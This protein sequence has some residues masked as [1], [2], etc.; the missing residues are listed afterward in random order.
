MSRKH[1]GANDRARRGAADCE[2]ELFDYILVYLESNFIYKM[3]IV[4][5]PA[6]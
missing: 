2:H 6:Q 4:A 5:R 3:T 1:C